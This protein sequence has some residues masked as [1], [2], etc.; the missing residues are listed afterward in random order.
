M[1]DSM[2]VSAAAQP[3]SFVHE[4]SEYAR[5]AELSVSRCIQSLAL[6]RAN[7]ANVQLRI[8]QTEAL[9]S[10]AD[11]LIL[12]LDQEL[13]SRTDSSAA[14]EELEPR[15]ENDPRMFSPR[16]ERQPA[17]QIQAQNKDL[18]LSFNLHR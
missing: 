7:F 12:A 5:A 4:A 11:R 9:I 3:D 18:T 8:S 10:A 6:A 2:A 14:D 1:L 15:Q 17:I 13:I 16:D